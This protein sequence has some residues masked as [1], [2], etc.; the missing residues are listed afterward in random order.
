MSFFYFECVL[1]RGQLTVVKSVAKMLTAMTVALPAL[2]SLGNMT[3]EQRIFL[4]H[5]NK[6]IEGSSE[7][8]NR[9]TNI[10]IM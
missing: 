5:N 8:V 1:S 9:T 6:L 4:Q 7:M 10:V 2:A 3:M